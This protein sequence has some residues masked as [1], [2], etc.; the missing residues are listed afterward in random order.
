MNKLL[1]MTAEVDS[2]RT[3]RHEMD[4][5]RFSLTKRKIADFLERMS[6]KK[7]AGKKADWED[8]LLKMSAAQATFEKLGR[9]LQKDNSFIDGSKDT[10]DTIICGDGIDTLAEYALY[11][12]LL[13]A[14]LK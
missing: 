9:L 3:H 11:F 7:L 8:D 2:Q 6:W 14:M 1:A 5:K 12:L 4:E 10:R 13:V